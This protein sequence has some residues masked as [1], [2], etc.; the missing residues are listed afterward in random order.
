M[1]LLGLASLYRS[2]RS[3]HFDRYKFRYRHGRVIFEVLFFIDTQPFELLFGSLGANFALKVNV[4]PGFVID[5]YLDE[6]DYNKLCE[7]LGLTPDP[8]NR[9]S[10]TAFFADFNERI[11]GR[12]TPAGVPRPHDV[13]VYRRNVEDAHKIYFCGWHDNTV[14]G[15]N[16]TEKNLDKTLKLLGLKA[17]DFCK[18]RN[19]SS[20]WTD[21]RERAIDMNIPL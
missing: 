17:H 15:E 5:A 20:C 8:N 19:T 6:D 11:P 21:N 3:Q 16:V 13:A 10:T 1:Q 9:F 18:R 2:M 7:V 14:R 12:A 4:R